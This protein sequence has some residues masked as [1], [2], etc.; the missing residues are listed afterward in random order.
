MQVP[1]R[2]RAF[3]IEA[4]HHNEALG[5]SFAPLR[6]LTEEAKSHP[7][8]YRDSIAL[9]DE[10][11]L[12]DE[13]LA[14]FRQRLHVH[15][16]DG[17]YFFYLQHTREA[18]EIVAR[19]VTE[20]LGLPPLKVRVDWLDGYL[21][22]EAEAIAAQIADFDAAGFRTERRRLMEGALQRA[23]YCVTGRPGSGKS[24]ALHALL[25]H[26]ERAGERSTVLAPTG[27]AA[28]RLSGEARREATWTAQ[29]IDRWIFASGL[30]GYLSGNVPLSTMGR[31]DRYESTHNIVIDEMSMVD[32]HHLALMFRA[33]EVHQ[34]ARSKG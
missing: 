20:R 4:L 19:Y 15:E 30:G 17:Q 3:A 14:H 32:L 7:L 12:S 33:L 18:E 16:V 1:E 13:H 5:H 8:F 29:T 22:K 6:V 24:Q 25:E 23:I 31:S 10:Q 11:F 34:P 2:L 28:L 21:D 9:S 27:K 26:F